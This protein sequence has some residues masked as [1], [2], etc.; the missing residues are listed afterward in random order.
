[1]VYESM[2]SMHILI[3]QTYKKKLHEPNNSVYF[4]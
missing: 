4:T 2:K 1:M 3:E